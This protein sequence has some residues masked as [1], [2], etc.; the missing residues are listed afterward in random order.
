MSLTMGEE[1]FS[2]DWLKRP[3]TTFLSYWKKN[4]IRELRQKSFENIL[5]YIMLNSAYMLEKI[6]SASA[7]TLK[8]KLLPL[9]AP[10]L[11]SLRSATHVKYRTLRKLSFHC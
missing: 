9:S 8:I 6:I 7:K 5:N 11:F 3:Y 4:C 2:L 1:D 10:K